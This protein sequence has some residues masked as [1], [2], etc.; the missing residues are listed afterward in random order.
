MKR[1]SVLL[2]VGILLCT[3]LTACGTSDPDTGT[4]STTRET[5]ENTTLEGMWNGTP[6]DEIN[7]VSQ[8]VSEGMS[9][10]RDEEF[11]NPDNGI[12]SDTNPLD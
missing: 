1:I 7:T 9:D 8:W 4:T 6:E 11:L 2:F 3:V 5:R 10:L 12:V